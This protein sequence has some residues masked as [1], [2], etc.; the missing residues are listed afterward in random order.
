LI[1][2]RN[3]LRSQWPNIPERRLVELCTAWARAAGHSAVLVFDGTAPTIGKPDPHC[4]V[5]GSGAESADSWLE[6]RAAELEA[7]GQPYWLV[8]SDRA[9]R[10]AAGRH[11]QRTIG[12]GAFARELVG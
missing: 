6:R 1:D 9:L 10:A 12:G 3:V 2:G 4:N 8:T 11:A 7:R 5:V